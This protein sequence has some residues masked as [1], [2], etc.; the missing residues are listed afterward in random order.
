[1]SICRFDAPPRHLRN[2]ANVRAVIARLKREIRR[3]EDW[4]KED[5][6]APLY[7]GNLKWNRRAHQVLVWCLWEEDSG[8]GGLKPEDMLRRQRAACEDGAGI[9][10][11]SWVLDGAGDESGEINVV[12]LRKDAPDGP[13]PSG[14]EGC[15][16]SAVD[17]AGRERI[18][19]GQ[20]S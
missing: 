6:D 17:V 9:N 4:D 14:P 12:A 18:E 15:I 5:F 8:R 20:G 11:L 13:G 10:A 16:T 1:V 19:H 3:D 2:E 7:K